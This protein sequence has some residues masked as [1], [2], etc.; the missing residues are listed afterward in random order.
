[1]TNTA[2]YQY[3]SV[4]QDDPDQ[5]LQDQQESC[6]HQGHYHASSSDPEANAE[7][8]NGTGLRPLPGISEPHT[9]CEACDRIEARR[10]RIA[11]KQHCCSEVAKVFVIL[12]LC[13]MGLGI[14]IAVHH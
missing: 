3:A 6:Q 12:F 8:S 7:S 11:S 1:M 4:S 14:T 2:W 10:E 13:L 5:Q 9:H